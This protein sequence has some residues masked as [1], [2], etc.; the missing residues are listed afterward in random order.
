M[1]GKLGCFQYF[2]IM[3]NAAMK[4][5]V[6]MYFVLLEVYLW[7]RFL[8]CGLLDQEINTCSFVIYCQ[9]PLERVVS[10]FIPTSSERDAWVA[11]S[12][13]G[14]LGLRS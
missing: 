14:C 12:L 4:N 11:Q 7:S 10:F 6:H 5:F 1:C 9:L 13:S 2:A 8:E 3:N